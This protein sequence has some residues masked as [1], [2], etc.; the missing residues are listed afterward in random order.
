M[1]KDANL[2]PLEESPTNPGLRSQEPGHVYMHALIEDPSVVID[3]VNFIHQARRTGVLTAVSGPVRKSI[4]FHQ[5][6]VI[7]AS[8]NQPEDRFGDIMVR[9]GLVSRDTLERALREVG[10]H[11][12]I[13]NV[14]ISRGALTNK[15]LWRVIRVQIEEILFS[16]LL[17]DRGELTLAHFD[18]AQV[19][20]RTALNTQHILLEGVRRKDEMEHLRGE[21]PPPDSVLMRLRLEA[22]VTLDTNERLIF[23]LVDGQRTLSK[24]AVDSGLGDFDSTR[25]LHH[26][27]KVGLVTVGTPLAP[28]VD[29]PA[30]SSPN[31]SVGDIVRAVNEAIQTIDMELRDAGHIGLIQHGV[32]NFFDDLDPALGELFDGVVPGKNGHLPPERIFTNLKVSQSTEKVVL[33]RRGLNEYVQFLLFLARETMDFDRVERL[34]SRVQDALAGLEL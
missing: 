21:L 19:P 1:A 28:T 13:G 29:R 27:L 10:P 20:N 16:A 33:L 5:G 34:A 3:L 30:P 11:R 14:L 9:L 18:P 22:G 4:Y 7:A 24:V 31:I 32:D 2:P 25:V 6:S 23:D 17:L 15:D 8:S 12:R 26:L